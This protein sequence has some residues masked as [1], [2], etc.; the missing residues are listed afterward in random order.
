V[1]VSESK[2]FV[3]IH[4][5]KCAGTSVRESLKKH[6]TR[7]NYFWMGEYCHVLNRHIDKAHIILK[8][9]AISYPE[10]F[11]LLDRFFVFTFV[12]DPYE[13]FYSSF[14]EYMKHHRKDI[15]IP[16]DS[17]K[18]MEMIN[19]FAVANITP[20]SVVNDFKLRHFPPQHLFVY[21]GNKSYVDFVGKVERMAE[22]IKVIEQAL[23][24]DNLIVQKKNVM[25]NR[26]PV[27]E[28][29]TQ[30]TRDII[31]RV[32]ERDFDLFFYDQ[33]MG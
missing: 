22:S 17:R 11:R 29:F 2:G 15:V 31:H 27:S 6:D 32:Y 8:N 12:R 28:I 4:N 33:C 16:P 10:I 14:F 24:I 7:D 13:R 21:I 20:N 26:Q 19:D 23:R 3:F 1:I 5:P 9:L 30:K 25:P 18:V